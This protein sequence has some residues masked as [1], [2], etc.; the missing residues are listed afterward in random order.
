MTKGNSVPDYVTIGFDKIDRDKHEVQ[1]RNR[2]AETA[3]A[4][5]G[6]TEAIH[7]LRRV[8]GLDKA[9]AHV[10]SVMETLV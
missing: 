9:R 5:L 4:R 2:N 1:E 8:G 3:G 6:V 10:A 7:A